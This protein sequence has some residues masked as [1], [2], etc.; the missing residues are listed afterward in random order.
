VY[1]PKPPTKRSGICA[2]RASDAVDIGVVGGIAKR[3][4]LRHGYRY[5]GKSSWS[6]AHERYLRELVLPHPAMKVDP[7]RI[8][9]RDRGGGLSASSGAMDLLENA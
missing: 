3:V 6:A 1:I 2:G 4:L 8:S 5:H 7:G 9:A